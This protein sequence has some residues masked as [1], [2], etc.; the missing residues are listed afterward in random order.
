MR[1]NVFEQYKPDGY[2]IFFA[3]DDRNSFNNIKSW[4]GEIQAIDEE[5]P[6]LLVA[7]KSDLRQASLNEEDLISYDEIQ[8]KCDEL[9]LQGFT[10]TSAVF[11]DD[12]SA[13]KAFK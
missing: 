8:R 5:A 10:E 3:I 9:G 6:I 13:K 11:T 7:N 12:E 2:M 1:M 4:Q